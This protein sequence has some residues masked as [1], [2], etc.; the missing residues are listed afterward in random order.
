MLDSLLDHRSDR[1]SIIANCR[2]WMPG[3]PRPRQSN[4]C[5]PGIWHGISSWWYSLERSF[6][7]SNIRWVQRGRDGQLQTCKYSLINKS[8]NNLHLLPSS[9][10]PL[11]AWIDLTSY[12]WNTV[13]KK[14]NKTTLNTHNA[15]LFFMHLFTPL[16]TELQGNHYVTYQLV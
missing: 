4:K 14:G 7:W 1:S 13:V 5:E 16:Y 3:M 2:F 9:F 11:E 12:L 10:S 8:Y 6:Q 15:T